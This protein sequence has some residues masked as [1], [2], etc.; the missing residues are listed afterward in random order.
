MLSCI[1][2][3]T[4]RVNSPEWFP[5]KVHLEL[6]SYFEISEF[7]I[8]SDYGNLFIEGGLEF[9]ELIIELLSFNFNTAFS[10]LC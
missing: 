6:M 5:I 4:W 1:K 8:A 10:Q 3:G 2:G 9:Y 7:N